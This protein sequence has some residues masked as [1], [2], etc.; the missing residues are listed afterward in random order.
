MEESSEELANKKGVKFMCKR[1]ILGGVIWLIL[2]AL[3]AFL[4]NA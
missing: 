4:Q 3:V 2:I 1:F